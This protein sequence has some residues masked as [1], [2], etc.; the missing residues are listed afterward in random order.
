MNDTANTAKENKTTE[1]G[2]ATNQD[3]KEIWEK[4]ADRLLQ[5][6]RRRVASQSEAEDLLQDVFEKIHKHK[7]DKIENL[8][9]WLYKIAHNTITDHYRKNEHSIDRNSENI[10]DVSHKLVAPVDNRENKTLENENSELGDLK[11]FEACVEPFILKLKL[12]EQGLLTQIR[13]GTPLTEIAKEMDIS[14]SNIKSKA[15]RAR[16]NLRKEFRKCCDYNI[17][18]TNGLKIKKINDPDSCS[19]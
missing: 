5:Y 2:S 13:E 14:Y 9:G 11:Q 4:F 17:S 19:C 6:I 8:A 15:N 18:D 12:S 16:N 1:A 10:D 3:T 7:S